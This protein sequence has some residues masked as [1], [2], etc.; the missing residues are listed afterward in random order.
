MAFKANLAAI[1]YMYSLRQSLQTDYN[2]SPLQHRFVMDLS[3]KHHVCVA[4][5]TV[6]GFLKFVHHDVGPS[7]VLQTPY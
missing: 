1:L 5:I 4:D 7:R 2:I 6:M 3:Q